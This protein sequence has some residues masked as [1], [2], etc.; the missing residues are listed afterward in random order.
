MLVAKGLDVTKVQ[1]IV[2]AVWDVR[3]DFSPRCAEPTRDDLIV[4]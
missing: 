2:L 3:S 4:R 1:R